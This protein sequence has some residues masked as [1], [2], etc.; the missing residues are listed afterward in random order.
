MQQTPLP[1]ALDAPQK[2]PRW[3]PPGPVAIGS[4]R[5]RPDPAGTLRVWVKVSHRRWRPRAV[6]V[7]ELHHGPVPAGCVVHH[8]DRNSLNDAP[9]NLMALTRAAHAA[10][11]AYPLAVVEQCS[12][13]MRLAF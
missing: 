7:Y 9:D 12:Q 5:T 8:R 10:E 1:L 13:S 4:V 6:I 3:R 11:H 2:P